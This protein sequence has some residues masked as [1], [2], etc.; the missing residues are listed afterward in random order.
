[1]IAWLAAL[2]CAPAEK[3]DESCTLAFVPSPGPLSEQTAATTDPVALAELRIREARLAGDPGFFTLAELALD[4]A[5]S[6]DPR[7]V[8]ARRWKGHIELQFHQFAQAERR[9]L[10][11]AAE[12][13]H[14]RDHLLLGDAKMEQGDLDGAELCY[15]RALQQRPTVESYDRT[16]QLAW[17]RGDLQG[18][19]A[20]ETLAFGATHEGDPEVAAWVA[21]ALGTWKMYAGETPNELGLALKLLPDYSHAHLAL[22]RY[23]LWLGENERARQHLTKAGPTVAATRA[24]AELDPSVDVK[25]VRLQDPRGYGLW[26]ALED[27]L[28]ALPLLETELASRRDATTVI[29]REWVAWKAGAPHSA[30]TVQ[31]A[32]AT[33]IAEPSVWLMAGEVLGDDALK[34]RAAAVVG[35][36]LPSERVRAA[37]QVH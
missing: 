5:L 28:A 26:L 10:E 18:A 32:L 36:L 30:Q 24:L 12:T 8:A 31:R 6:R 33:G 29:G 20:Q 27:P 16:A 3:V 7:D 35:G 1:M 22:G 2:A 23:W 34:A 37:V 21:T 25:A 11:L 14:W 13:D 17:L 9:L 15:E 4:C 19:I